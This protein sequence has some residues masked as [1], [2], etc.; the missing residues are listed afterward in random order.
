MSDAESLEMIA[1][2]FER[3]APLTLSSEE[4]TESRDASE[5]AKTCHHVMSTTGQTSQA[6]L[7]TPWSPRS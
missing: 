7:C 2:T 3:V 1:H 6:Y 5:P 4:S